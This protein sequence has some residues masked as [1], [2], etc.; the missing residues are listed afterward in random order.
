M[1]TRMETILVEG[2]NNFGWEKPGQGQDKNG[3]RIYSLPSLK[4]CS[5]PPLACVKTSEQLSEGRKKEGRF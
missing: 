3:R 2:S 5:T 1:R 4:F